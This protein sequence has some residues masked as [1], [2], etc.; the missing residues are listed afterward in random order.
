MVCRVLCF[1]VGIGL[2]FL[3]SV[4]LIG[5]PSVPTPQQ[6]TTNGYDYCCD[7]L[8]DFTG[9]N[10]ANAAQRARDNAIKSF[11][12][13]HPK[14]SIISAILASSCGSVYDGPPIT[15]LCSAAGGKGKY[16]VCQLVT[17]TYTEPS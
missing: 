7:K 15:G 9:D 13:A 2:V 6:A 12:C 4:L 11:K 3:S 1:V 17:I 14:A 16:G 10:L 8:G 5:C